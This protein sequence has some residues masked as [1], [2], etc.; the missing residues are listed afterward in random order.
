MAVLCEAL[1]LV[2]RRSAIVRVFADWAEFMATVPDN[3]T[4]CC[5]DDLVRVGFFAPQE[6]M[7]QAEIWQASGLMLVVGDTFVDMAVV[8]QQNGATL[9]CEWLEFMHI[10]MNDHGGKIAVCWELHHP[11]VSSVGWH[12]PLDDN[13]EMAVVMPAGWQFEQSLSHS[14]RFIPD[15]AKRRK[16]RR[17]R[18]Q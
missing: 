9:P 16:T 13:G 15:Q 4:F 6:V 10:D 8:D 12:V 18:G 5:D 14:F 3:G 7:Q 17:E 1:S 2:V 11:R